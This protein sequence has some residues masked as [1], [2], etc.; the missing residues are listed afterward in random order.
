[1]PAAPAGHIPLRANQSEVLVNY[2]LWT[3]LFGVFTTLSPIIPIQGAGWDKF[4][5][6]QPWAGI[7][8]AIS[9]VLM[10]IVY[11]S[12]PDFA[13]GPGAP[14]LVAAFWI[15]GITMAVFAGW[16]GDRVQQQRDLARIA[17]AT[18][19]VMQQVSPPLPQFQPQQP[20]QPPP[21]QPQPPA[22]PPSGTK[23]GEEITGTSADAGKT[24]PPKSQA[25]KIPTEEEEKKKQ[26]GSS[27]I[28]LARDFD[29]VK[30]DLS[31]NDKKIV[32]AALNEIQWFFQ[33]D[34][35]EGV[36]ELLVGHL[37]NPDEE[38]V[39]AVMKALKTWGDATN[40]VA[41]IPFAT[42]DSPELRAEA[43]GLLGKFRDPQGLAALVDAL[44]KD[45]DLAKEALIR[46]GKS[47]EAA[48][49]KGLKHKAKV[50]KLECLRIIDSL[51]LKKAQGDIRRMA[52]YETDG[53]VKG[54]ARRVADSLAKKKG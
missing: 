49:I 28:G 10:M 8:I 34:Q 54:E 39:L 7:I 25:P 9:G 36:G 48:L 20:V 30:K 4:I 24:A 38:I 13:R 12:G 35:R 43:I 2:G 6:L 11:Q 21:Q 27:G 29:V 32:L 23:D 26:S 50:V 53:E 47:A 22:L 18:A 45:K 46:A 3:L 19:P 37:S 31:S 42:H 14:L 5:A 15:V 17:E 40:A 33:R 44:E 1:V 51:G 16:I 52:E 41:I